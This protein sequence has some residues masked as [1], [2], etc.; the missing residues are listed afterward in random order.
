MDKLKRSLAEEIKIATQPEKI[1]GADVWKSEDGE[2]MFAVAGD[3]IL[4]GHS[5]SVQKCLLAAA[6]RQDTGFRQRFVEASGLRAPAV[7][8]GS[9]VDPTAALVKVLA[10][11]KSETEPLSQ[12]FRISTSFTPNAIQR[13]EVS[14]FGLIGSIV[15]QF[16][17]D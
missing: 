8:V 15:E 6:S 12:R 16:A 7:T 9:D 17:G 10:A 5:E 11:R 2:L 13:V 3:K 1:E 4:L 14:D